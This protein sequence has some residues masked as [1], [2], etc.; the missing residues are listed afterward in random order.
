VTLTFWRLGKIE[1]WDA[2]FY[3]VAQFIGG[4][5][6]VLLATQLLSRML[7]ADMAVQLCGHRAW[8][9]RT[10]GRVCGRS[11][12]LVRLDAD[13]ADGVEPARR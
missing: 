13:G 6:G 7:I 11:G 5:A 1:G 10:V 9:G 8:R 12:D 3:I 4:A 2:L